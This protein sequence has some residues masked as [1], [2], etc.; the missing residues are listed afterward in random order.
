LLSVIYSAPDQDAIEQNKSWP[1]AHGC[2]SGFSI[3]KLIE[4][5]GKFELVDE[6]GAQPWLMALRKNAKR[7]GTLGYPMPGMAQIFVALDRT[8]F[9][10]AAPI[11]PVLKKGI[12]ISEIEKYYESG[13]GKEF[14]ENHSVA[15][16]LDPEQAFFCPFGWQFHVVYYKNVEIKKAKKTEEPSLDIAYMLACPVFEQSW[17][18]K[19]GENVSQAVQHVNMTHFKYKHSNKMWQQREATF[20]TF[21]EDKE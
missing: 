20:N 12:A 21:F 3:T 13:D 5:W 6:P 9:I 2:V 18:D 10:K 15:L 19:V 16:K 11:D 8:V 7:F 17:K 14:L 1:G 4:K